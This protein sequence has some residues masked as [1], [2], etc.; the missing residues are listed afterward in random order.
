MLSYRHESGARVIH[1]PKALGAFTR[2][3]LPEHA[4]YLL[5]DVH[6]APA[7]MLHKI[8]RLLPPLR[9][10]ALKAVFL[11]LKLNTWS[12]ADQIPRWLEQIRG[13][14]LRDVRARQLPSNRQEICVVGRV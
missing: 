6:L 10:R 7:V 5:V 14:G 2:D 9:E 13:Y 1:I 12:M 3:E 8:R 4:A 11:T